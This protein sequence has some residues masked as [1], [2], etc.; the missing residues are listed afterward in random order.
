MQI[1][2]TGLLLW[3]LEQIENGISTD[4]EPIADR[5]LADSAKVANIQ[6]GNKRI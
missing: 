5:V 2:L 1:I 6:L 3:L 4:T